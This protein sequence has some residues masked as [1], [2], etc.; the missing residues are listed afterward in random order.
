MSAEDIA[1]SR[2]AVGQVSTSLATLEYDWVEVELWNVRGMTTEKDTFGYKADSSKTYTLDYSVERYNWND[3]WYL[4]AD[5]AEADAE[6]VLDEQVDISRVQDAAQANYDGRYYWNN[7]DVLISYNSSGDIIY[8]VSFN[9]YDTYTAAEMA[10]LALTQDVDYAQY[11]FGSLVPAVPGTTD[12]T[13]YGED[14]VAG[15]DADFEATVSY[16]DAKDAG[17]NNSIVVTNGKIVSGDKTTAVK[18]AGDTYEGIILGDDGKYY[19]FK[20]T[21]SAAGTDAT[22]TFKATGK[23]AT[24]TNMEMPLD[25]Y[26][27]QEYIDQ[28]SIPAGATVEWTFETNAGKTFSFKGK[29]AVNVPTGVTTTEIAGVTAVV[30]AEDG[31]T[32][33]TYMDATTASGAEAAALA[34]AQKLVAG[35]VYTVY[36]NGAA[37]WLNEDDAYA[38][39]PTG[40]DNWWVNVPGGTTTNIEVPLSV[41]INETL[42]GTDYTVKSD[43]FEPATAGATS[44]T[45]GRDGWTQTYT[46]VVNLMKDGHSAGKVTVTY[47]QVFCDVNAEQTAENDIK[48]LKEAVKSRIGTSVSYATDST[49]TAFVERIEARIEATT[50]YTITDATVTNAVPASYAENDVITV[51]YTFVCNGV[52]YSDSTV[53]TVIA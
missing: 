19:S 49:W 11:V 38:N 2:Y 48:A 47:K 22:L 33:K 3:V 50:G 21:Q 13:F 35:E 43:V 44:G 18:V 6:D 41:L 42:K 34:A 23:E 46:Q 17:D 25:E 31:K 51:S 40:E 30:T 20:L 45:P 7:N 24:A 26:T 15:A 39:V 27:I 1:N 36:Y 53:V 5:L 14:T 52:T 16:A 9:N 10:Y 37:W 28:F 32:S 29:T 8:A 12:V 4:D